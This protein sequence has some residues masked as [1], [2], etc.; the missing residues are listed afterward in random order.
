MP[1]AGDASRRVQIY[2]GGNAALDAAPGTTSRGTAMTE[3]P[4]PP[5]LAARVRLPAPAGMHRPRLAGPLIV[6]AAYRVGTVVAPAGAGKTTLLVEV[7]QACAW[8][9]AWLTLDDRIGGL[10]SFLAHLH[11]AAAAAAGLPAG[12]W[13]SIENAIVDLD[14]HLTDN[15]LIVLDDL[16]AVDGQPAEAAVQLLLDYLP[17]K[18]RVLVAARWRPNLDLHRLRLAGQIREVDADALRFRTWEVEELFRDCHGVRLRPEEVTALTRSTD[19]WAAGL[20]LFH[21]ATRGRPASERAK[22]L[23]GLGNTRLTREYLTMHVLSAVSADE[24]DFLVR[25]SVFDRLTEKRCDSLLGRTGSGLQLAELERR[26]LFTFVEDDGRTYRYHEVLRIHLLERLV[27]EH[28]EERAQE[29][30]GAA[31]RLCEE[32]GALTEALLS[33]CR[34]GDWEQVRRLLGQGGRR[35]ADDP[36]AWFE[37]LPAA[38]RDSDPWVLL[39][40]ARRLAADG[41][42]EAAA[43]TYRDAATAFGSETPARV[44][45]E[46]AELD[47]WLHPA[48][49]RDTTWLRTLRAVLAD[50]G[51]H[52]EGSADPPQTALVRGIAAFVAGEIA[53]A[54]QRFDTITAGIGAS[55]VIETV[56]A[57][58]RAACALLTQDAQAGETVEEGVAAAELLGHAAVLRVAAAVRALYFGYGNRHVL[59]LLDA[60]G[61]AGD[62]WGVGALVLLGS[63]AGL[64]VPDDAMFPADELPAPALPPS[65]GLAPGQVWPDDEPMHLRAYRQLAMALDHTAGIFDE[66]TAG[67]LATWARASALLAWRRAGAPLDEDEAAR[68][69]RA[70][71]RLGPAPHAL[72][73]VGSVPPPSAAPPPSHAAGPPPSPS[74]ASGAPFAPGSGATSGQTHPHEVA[75]RIAA[76]AGVGSWVERL[77]ASLSGGGRPPAAVMPA[78]MTG[79]V[80]AAVDADA[81]SPAPAGEPPAA[82]RRLTVRCLGRF[83]LEIDG[84][85]VGLAGVQ[86][87]NLELLHVLA[88]HADRPLH[89]D[90]LIEL[91]WPD[92][93]PAQANHSLQ[94]AVSALRGLLEP[95][96]PRGRRGL[97]R[98][99]GQGYLLALVD[100]DD[101]D[102]RRLERLLDAAAAARRSGDVE[103]EYQRLASAIELYAGDVLPGGGPADWLLAE[104][105]R[106]RTTIAAGCERAAAI[107]TETGRH[108][109]A[110]RHAELGLEVDRYR[111][112][113][114][115]TLVVAL[116]SGGQPAAAARAEAR[117]EAMLADLGIEL[118][119]AEPPLGAGHGPAWPT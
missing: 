36:A 88:V 118:T 111:D 116:R 80:A 110:V 51:P 15:L 46:L 21:L 90:Q 13:T 70:A 30:H 8:P 47:D 12:S 75:R 58:G 85:P 64:P 76:E 91:I 31:A 82:E 26:G 34:S 104:R 11:A 83:E 5:I 108:K 66:L 3:A 105:D 61:R 14:R 117:Y 65:T 106:L 52:V 102:I 32:D 33:Y 37:L 107:S 60:A 2:A 54:R 16:H 96:V 40:M 35:L 55:P 113:L 42:L 1:E 6:P 103:A 44:H 43:D 87:R 97:L 93:A 100:P 89:R 9:T 67:A 114:W 39:A 53:L 28:G 101:H 10:D 79:T 112:G 48:P 63:F 18:V 92:A 23:S 4:V 29:V 74:A 68:V 49:R 119:S 72:A 109:D 20:Q 56:A 50:P 25:T 62:R 94:V 59:H 99:A 57:V 73:L 41:S 19:G 38:I 71:A 95:A 115:R 69:V 24:R 22:I 81:A 77:I 7:A 27:L 86:P 78:G 98:R 17:P 45:R 84:V